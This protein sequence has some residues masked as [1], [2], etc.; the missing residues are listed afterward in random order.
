[1]G[2]NAYEHLGGMRPQLLAFDPDVS[3]TS[4]GRENEIHCGLQP[5]FHRFWCLIAWDTK[6]AYRSASTSSRTPLRRGFAFGVS[7]PRY[8]HRHPATRTK[9]INSHICDI[10]HI[11]LH[12]PFG[13]R[14]AYRK[15][16]LSQNFTLKNGEF[17]VLL[18][19]CEC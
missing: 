5:E 1:M 18:I 10:K 9:D 15:R 17:T 13:H 19:C 4:N 16:S 12:D 8:A 14:Y 7:L 3:C 6:P 2:L 11:S